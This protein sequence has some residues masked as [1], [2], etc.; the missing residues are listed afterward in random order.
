MKTLLLEMQMSLPETLK[1]SAVGFLLVLAVL[2]AIALL[3][4]A[5]SKA[6]NAAASSSKN[7]IKEEKFVSELSAFA[8][9]TEQAAPAA[10]VPQ[11]APPAQ[12]T[13]MP[14]VPKGYVR[15]ENVS[16]PTAATIMAILSH[17]TGIPLNRLAFSSI[18]LLRDELVLE[19]LDDATAA[20]IM[21]II[22]N[23]TGTPL[24]ELDFKSIK[25]IKEN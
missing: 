6:F 8:P 14:P 17:Q 1:T 25:L 20:V 24:N 19:G 4:L 18:K 7:V 9:K 11:A 12:T 2:A 3:I 15:L 21:A 13:D 5:V 16:E 22:S 23:K 10:A